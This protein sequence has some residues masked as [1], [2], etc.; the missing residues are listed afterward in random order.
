MD[1][2]LDWRVGDNFR[3]FGCEYSGSSDCIYKLV[4]QTVNLHDKSLHDNFSD[5]LLLGHMEC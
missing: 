5:V 2:I 3:A 4:L 1:I